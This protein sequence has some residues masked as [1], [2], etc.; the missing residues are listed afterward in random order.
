MPLLRTA[1]S[2]SAQRL[3]IGP[4]PRLRTDQAVEAGRTGR[5]CRRPLLERGHVY[6]QIRVGGEFRRQHRSHLRVRLDTGHGHA[7]GRERGGGDAGTGADLEGSPAG[8][9]RDHVVDH[10]VW[11]PRPVLVVVCGG[12]AETSRAGAVDAGGLGHADHPHPAGLSA[13]YCTGTS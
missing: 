4:V 2:A 7:P 8:Q 11:V 9:R 12:C 1:A 3:R 5:P 6:V 13:G 10:L